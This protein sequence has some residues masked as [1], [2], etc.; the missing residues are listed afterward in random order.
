MDYTDVYPNPD[1]ELEYF[2]YYRMEPESISR[3]TVAS[4]SVAT[5]K[6][7]SPVVSSMIISS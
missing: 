6:G 3:T 1:V 7:S 4:S 2:F 5:G